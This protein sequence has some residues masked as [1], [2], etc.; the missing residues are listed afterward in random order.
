MGK[1][2]KNVLNMRIYF[3]YRNLKREKEFFVVVWERIL[4]IKFLSESLMTGLLQSEKIYVLYK[5]KDLIKSRKVYK[6]QILLKKS[7]MWSV[8]YN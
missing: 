7:C 5:T 4:W 8:G 6:G 3:Q 2:A 1:E